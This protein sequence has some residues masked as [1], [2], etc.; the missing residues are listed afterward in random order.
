MMIVLKPGVCV[1]WQAAS[2]LDDATTTTTTASTD[3]EDD[4]DSLVPSGWVEE[5]AAAERQLRE[6]DGEMQAPEAGFEDDQVLCGFDNEESSCEAHHEVEQEPEPEPEP[7]NDAVLDEMVIVLK[8]FVCVLFGRLPR[9]WTMQQQQQ[10][11]LTRR[12]TTL[13][14]YHQGGV[15]RWQQP[16]ASF[17]STKAKC[18]RQKRVSQMRRCG[19]I[20]R[21]TG[22]ERVCE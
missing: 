2:E 8:P 17:E 16:S 22:R 9:S 12:M 14:W 13:R 6:H 18:R 10:H 15:R 5:M 3:E 19:E 4:D 20:G 21:A 1:V 7:V 11:R